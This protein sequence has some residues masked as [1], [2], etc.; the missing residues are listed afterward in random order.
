M[1]RELVH[2]AYNETLDYVELAGLS[3]E[4]KPT[5]GIVTGSTFMEADTGDVYVYAEGDT[6][7][8]NKIGGAGE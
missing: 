4:E 3:T 1:I 7:S 5:G 2:R 6:P 8:W